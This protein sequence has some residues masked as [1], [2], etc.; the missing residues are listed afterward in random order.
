MTRDEILRCV[1]SDDPL[2]TSR[3]IDRFVNSL[4]NKIEA[5]THRPVLIKIVR[6]IGYRLETPEA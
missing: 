3:S 2:V 1:W 5:D 4:R 6:N